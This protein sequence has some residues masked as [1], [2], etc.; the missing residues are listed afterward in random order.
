LIMG[1]MGAIGSAVGGFVLGTWGFYPLNA[2]G[3]A[4][5][6]GPLIGVWLLR[7]RTLSPRQ[8]G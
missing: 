5:V 2:L 7:P 4:C 8:A 1:L 3:A 6:V